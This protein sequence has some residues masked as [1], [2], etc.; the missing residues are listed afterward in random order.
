VVQN[1]LIAQLWFSWHDPKARTKGA[2]HTATQHLQ[3]KVGVEAEDGHALT[4]PALAL[5]LVFVLVVKRE[6]SRRCSTGL[7][8]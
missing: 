3:A 1:A 8:R 4:K 2:T 6:R 7:K 5:S